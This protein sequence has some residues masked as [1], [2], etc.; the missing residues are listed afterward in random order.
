MSMLPA[1]E[2]PQSGLSGMFTGG[3]HQ[4]GAEMKLFKYGVGR[5]L[6]VA[7]S[8]IDMIALDLITRDA[9]LCQIQTLEMGLALAGDEPAAM[10]IVGELVMLQLEIN[11]AIIRAA[12][13]R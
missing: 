4:R 2:G 13:G 7:K 3:L 1:S 11:K 10:A 6:E 12:V 5:Q 9:M 8:K